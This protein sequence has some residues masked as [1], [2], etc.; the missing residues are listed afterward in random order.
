MM[1]ASVSSAIFDSSSAGL[2]HNL[3]TAFGAR[4]DVG[5][6]DFPHRFLHALFPVA[7][8]PIHYRSGRR[9]VGLNYVFRFGDALAREHQPRREHVRVAAQSLDGFA[10]LDH[11]AIGALIQRVVA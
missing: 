3:H 6:L 10:L 4:R 2:W 8:I 11:L 9:P 7:T 1:S 5:R